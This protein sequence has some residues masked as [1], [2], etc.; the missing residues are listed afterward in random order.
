MTQ[1][2]QVQHFEKFSDV[3]DFHFLCSTFALSPS[4]AIKIFQ[5]DEYLCLKKFSSIWWKRIHFNYFFIF[6][7][8]IFIYNN[9]ISTKKKTK[10]VLLWSRRLE[11]LNISF[12]KFHF[13][14]WQS[15]ISCNKKEYFCYRLTKHCSLYTFTTISFFL[16]L[17]NKFLQQCQI[18]MCFALWNVIFF[19]VF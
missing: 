18:S 19:C 5:K 17:Y 4:N 8:K 9:R 15:N 6:W 7:N 16:F 1:Q 3:C 12:L 13:S 11:G 2:V 14:S 10:F